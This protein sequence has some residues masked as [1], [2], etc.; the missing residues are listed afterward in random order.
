MT[1][2]GIYNAALKLIAENKEDSVHDYEERAP[3]LIATFCAEHSEKDKALRS[4]IGA[5]ASTAENSLFIGLD[6][7]FP[8]LD[9]F[10]ASAAL[11]LA[12]MLVIDDFPNLSDNLFDKYCYRISR[13][14]DNITG[15]C[16][17]TKDKYFGG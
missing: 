7:V 4:F 3:Y 10:S 15:I 12:S 16:E 8:L 1:C 9:K 5:P 13:I 2:R 11:Y 6:D 17:T 14:Y